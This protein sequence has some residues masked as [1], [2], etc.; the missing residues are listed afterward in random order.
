MKG[1]GGEKGFSAVAFAAWLGADAKPEFGPKAS[2]GLFAIHRGAEL[3]LPR[4][5][6][7]YRHV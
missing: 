3:A 1:E 7:V 6:G 2:K 5:F 4:L